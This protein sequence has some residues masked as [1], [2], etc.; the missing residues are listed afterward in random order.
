MAL[1]NPMDRTSLNDALGSILSGNILAEGSHRGRAI[2]PL[3]ASRYGVP[4]AETSYA[5]AA[6]APSAKPAGLNI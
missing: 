5:L 2:E 1:E 4:G 3:T 6:A